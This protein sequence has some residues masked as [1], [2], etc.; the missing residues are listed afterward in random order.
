MDNKIH[1]VIFDLG[2]VLIDVDFNKGFFPLLRSSM[3]N[4]LSDRIEEVFANSLFIDFNKG[5][6]NAREFYEAL[7]RRY[8]L[9]VDFTTFKHQWCNVFTEIPGMEKLVKTL[10]GKYVVGLLSDT[11]PLHWEYCLHHFPFLHMFAAPTL[12]F[13][14]GRVKPDAGCY[15]AAANNVNTPVEHCLF[16]DDRPD[17]V[18]GAIAAGM[19]AVR[20]SG[21]EALRH[22]LKSLQLL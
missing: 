12:S 6:I 9:Q 18:Q 10:S 7:S 11:D 4:P 16:I 3:A 17:N 2:R 14:I 15:Q 19:K 13:N 8:N 1:A 21:S 20:F 5:L 22:Q